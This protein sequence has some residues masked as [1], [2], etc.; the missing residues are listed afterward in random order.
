M[1]RAREALRGQN[2]EPVATPARVIREKEFLAMG[3]KMVGKPD[4]VIGSE[5]RDYKSGSIYET[6]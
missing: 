3:G 6:V 1:L 2:P 5:I 4:V